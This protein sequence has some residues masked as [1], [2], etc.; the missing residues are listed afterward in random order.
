MP[1]SIGIHHDGSELYVDDVNPSL[2]DSVTVYLRISRKFQPDVVLLRSVRDGEPVSVPAK[3]VDRPGIAGDDD[4]YAAEL[5]VHNPRTN[6]RWLVSGGN[7]GYGWVNQMGW[8]SHDINDSSDFA[9]TVFEPIAQWA[10]STVFYQ[11]FPDR[12]AKSEHTYDVPSWA[13]P[14]TWDQWPQGR[15]PQT[16]FEYFGG[17]FWGVIDHLDDIVELGVNALYFTP[18]FPAGS[19]HRYDASNFDCVDP[20]LGGDEALISLVEAAHARGLKVIGDITLNHSGDKHEWFLSAQAGDPRTRDFYIFND[21]LEHGY[22]SWIGVKSL[23]KFN[24]ASEKFRETMITGE[25]SVLRKWLKAPFN[26]DGWRVDVANMS[27]RL[28]ALDMTHDVARL[29][30]EAVQA[31]GADKILIGEHNHDAGGDLDG[32]GWQGNMNYTSFRNPVCNWL[33]ADEHINVSI[34]DWGKAP[35]GI[36]PSITAENML[37]VA[38]SFSSR[39][40]W[41]SYSASWNLLSSHDSPRIRSVV[42]TSE[43]QHAAATLAFTMPGSVMLF[44]GD[45]IGSR[46]MWGEDS[47]SPYPWN[48]SSKWDREVLETYKKLIALRTSSSALANGGMRIVHVSDDV[49]AYLREDA[50]ERYLVVCSRAGSDDVKID[51]EWLEIAAIEPLFGFAATLANGVIQ[52]EIP[53][54]GSGIWQVS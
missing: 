49:I 35:F 38:R 11:I 18:F 37:E 31:E 17:D 34:A 16:A 36:M 20:L 2:G 30:R 27:G 42:D 26:L 39:M 1:T 22:E 52:V 32:D 47:R 43:R 6:Y 15:G 4:W 25:N 19:L 10:K 51:A 5:I 14:R 8:N 45:E 21:E 7:V 24:Y 23:P 48:D 29:A 53:T 40:P 28:G 3:K 44:A 41:Q 33:V 9:L 12:F 54:A 50:S 13:V 46:G